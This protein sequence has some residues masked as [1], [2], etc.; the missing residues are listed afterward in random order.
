M[1]NLQQADDEYYVS[2]SY[3][4]QLANRAA[5]LFERSELEEKRILLK[6]VLQNAVLD[7]RTVRY[8]LLKPFDQIFFYA[9]RSM[10]LRD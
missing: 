2:A 7:G 3:L 1:D 6:M 9:S 8:D 5:E 4:L 10:W